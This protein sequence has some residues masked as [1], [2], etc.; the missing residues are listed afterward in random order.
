[1]TELEKHV[2]TK[3]FNDDI[4][5]FYIRFVDDTLVLAKPTAFDSILEKLNNNLTKKVYNGY[6]D[7]GNVHFLDIKIDGTETDVYFKPTHTGQYSYFTSQSPWRLKTAWARSLFNRASKICSSQHALNGQIRKLKQFLS[8]NGY[9]SY[10]AKSLI[11][12]FRSKERR[13]AKRG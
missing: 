12:S 2:V 3:L 6:F 7:D 4:I 5:K 1:M 8:W 11:R 9:P 13:A 10:V